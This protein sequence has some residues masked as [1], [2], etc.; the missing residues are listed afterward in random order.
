[1]VFIRFHLLLP[2]ANYDSFLD[3]PATA[4]IRPTRIIQHVAFHPIVALVQSE[5]PTNNWSFSMSNRWSLNERPIQTGKY[6]KF[7]DKKWIFIA[8]VSTFP[9]AQI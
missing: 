4:A 1:V 5:N 8:C 2:L 6:F 3:A 9:K 7:E